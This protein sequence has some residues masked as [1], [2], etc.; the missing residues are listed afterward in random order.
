MRILASVL[1]LVAVSGLLLVSAAPASAAVVDTQTVSA[2]SQPNRIAVTPDGNQTWTLDIG[3]KALI[4]YTS[5]TT[6]SPIASWP[7]PGSD[8]GSADV[9]VLADGKRA[10]VTDWSCNCVDLVDL[11]TG[12]ITHPPTINGDSPSAIAMSP[13]GSKVVISYLVGGSPYAAVYNTSDWSYVWMWAF[14]SANL[15]A[16]AFSPDGTKFAAAAYSINKVLVA[17]LDTLGLGATLD[18]VDAPGSVTYSP[19]GA[20][21][22]VGSFIGHSIRKFDA[23]TGTEL[24]SLSTNMTT[25]I[26]VS[27]DGTQ[28]WASQPVTA[29]VSIFATADLSVID[30]I[31]FSGNAGGIAFAQSGCQAWVVQQL[32]S[33]DT[34]F[35]LDPCLPGPPPALPDTGASPSVIGTSIAVSVGL[36]VAGALALIVVRRRT[37]PA[38]R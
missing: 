13:D 1:G 8:Y 15:N 30:A 28:L 36:L 18:T 23:T 16:L 26:A 24:A 6:L 19:D 10:V 3:G 34:V 7:L 2:G 37:S 33:K 32:G 20:S 4:G 35:D 27:P 31:P 5:G 25:S 29:Q 14:F 17:D 11:T 21:I 38:A 22:F 9:V 12:T